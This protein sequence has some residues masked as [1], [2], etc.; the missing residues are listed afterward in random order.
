VHVATQSTKDTRKLCV[1]VPACR[2]YPKAPRYR[3][4]RIVPVSSATRPLAVRTHSAIRLN[5]DAI[6]DGVANP[7]LAAKVSLGCLY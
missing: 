3:F 6:V 4:I 2:S 1:D 7:L 5:P